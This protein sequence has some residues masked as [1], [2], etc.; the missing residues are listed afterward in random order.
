MTRPATYTSPTHAVG[1]AMVL[2]QLAISVQLIAGVAKMP[3]LRN[4]TADGLADM[5]PVVM[6]TSL[7][8]ALA[9]I[10][11]TSR[12]CRDAD[13][14]IV[15]LR[16][17]AAAKAALSG[18]SL[19]YAASLTFTYGWAGGA[20][21]QTY[22]WALGLGFAVRSWQIRRDVRRVRAAKLAAIPASPPPLGEPSDKEA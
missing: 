1:V 22:A 15:A 8:V 17:E 18:M 10:V 20:T 7:V 14:T 4:A 9:A 13:S 5:L 21:T 12:S 2:A 16:V 6:F 19:A 3:A 11:V